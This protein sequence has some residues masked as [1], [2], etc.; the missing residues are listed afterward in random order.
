MTPRLQQEEAILKVIRG[1]GDLGLR[2]QLSGLDSVDHPLK[3]R[4]TKA[5]TA[6]TLVLGRNFRRCAWVSPLLSWPLQSSARAQ[7]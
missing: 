2:G 7:G 6:R 5:L 3:R 4:S 1:G